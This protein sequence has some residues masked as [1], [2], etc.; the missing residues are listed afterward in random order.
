MEPACG[1]QELTAVQIRLDDLRTGGDALHVAAP[2]RQR[3]R[4]VARC[5]HRSRVD[6]HHDS[7]AMTPT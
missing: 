2:T 6:D 5:H 7:E 1:Y 4:E 3:S